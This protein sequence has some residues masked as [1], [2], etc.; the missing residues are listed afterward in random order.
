MGKEKYDNAKAFRPISLSNYLLKGLEKLCVW[1]MDTDL[2]K[3][4]IHI[5][6]HGFQKSKCT[7]TAISKTINSVEK[8]LEK[9]QILYRGIP[10]YTSCL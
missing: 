1:K 10:R 9:K 3:L 7:E 6:Q 5:N 2:R 4:P 8:H